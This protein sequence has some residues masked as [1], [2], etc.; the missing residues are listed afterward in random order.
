MRGLTISAHGGVD[1]IEYRDD[2]VK[3]EY[4]R[5]I[6]D[7]TKAI[8]INPAFADAYDNRGYTYYSL[9]RYEEALYDHNKAIELGPTSYA[10]VYNNRGLAYL[11]KGALDRAIQDFDEAVRVK[12]GFVQGFNDRGTVYFQKRNSFGPRRFTFVNFSRFSAQFF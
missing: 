3:G 7:Y 11:A 5:A 2:L 6:A 12:P 1:R 9:K 4:D 8:E 10:S